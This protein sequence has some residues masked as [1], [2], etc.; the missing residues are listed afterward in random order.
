[1]S[2]SLDKLIDEAVTVK[3]SHPWMDSNA[4]YNI[5]VMDKFI[6]CETSEVLA[7][8]MA[9]ML[10]V[11]LKQFVDSAFEKCIEPFNF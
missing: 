9:Y 4:V 5:Y 1:M 7:E 11:A 2:E 8:R 3:K 10:K 6:S